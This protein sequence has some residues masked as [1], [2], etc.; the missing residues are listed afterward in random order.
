MKFS[1]YTVFSLDFCRKGLEYAIEHTL[2]M[3][4]DSIEH[5][6]FSDGQQLKLRSLAQAKSM[7]RELDANSLSVTCYSMV[8]DVFEKDQKSLFDNMLKNI[9][10]AAELG[11]PYF[12]HTVI[13]WYD[14]SMKTFSYDSALKSVADLLEEIA[15]RCNEY[16]MICLYEP[17]GIYFNGVDGL[18]KLLCEMKDRGCDVGICGDTGNSLFVDC[19]PLDIFKEFRRD[20]RH[21]HI[22]DYYFG[23]EREGKKEYTT[24]SG[25]NIYDSPIGD[26]AAEIDKCLGLIPSY[27]GAMSFEIDVDDETMKRAVDYVKKLLKN[28]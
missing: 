21:V 14:Y 1:N 3:G 28:Q 20:I 22:K 5:I 26:G 24:L 27:D 2:K 25:M 4:F 15:K 23:E 16:G 7:K 9:E 10:Y 6:E 18:S 8:Y 13:P 11:S 17:Q 19:P 12:H